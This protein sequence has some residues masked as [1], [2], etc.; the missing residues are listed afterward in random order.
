MTLRK[1]MIKVAVLSDVH[2][3]WYALKSVI[4]QSEF[5]NC[6]LIIF[7]G[8]AVGYYYQP[9]KVINYLRKKL[10]TFGNLLILL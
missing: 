3:N 10:L 5:Q 9:E 1:A 7:G 2:A 4:S 6:D 8:D